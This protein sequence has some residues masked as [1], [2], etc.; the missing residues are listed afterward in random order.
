MP[1]IRIA[2]IGLGLVSDAHLDSFKLLDNINIV[3]VCD[4]REE[5]TRLIA[6]EWNATAYSDYQKLLAKEQV[7][8]V[9][10]LTPASIHLDVIKTAA[11]VGTHIFCEKPIAVSIEDA[12]AIINVCADAKVKLFYGS[13]YRYLPAVRAA[14]EL[15]RQGKI[16]EIQLMSEQGVGGNGL[17]NCSQLSFTHYPEGGPGGPAWGIMDH[18]VHLVDVFSWFADSKIVDVIGQG[19]ISGGAPDTEYMIMKFVSGAMGHLLY[20]AASYSTVLPNEGMYSG[21]QGYR[22]DSS[23]SEPGLW[24][25]D[26]DSISVYGTT[27]SLRI[28]Y[29]T[30]A[31]YLNTGDG[32]KQIP[33]SGRTPFG[34]F[35]TQLETCIASIVEDLPPPISGEVGKTTLETMLR[36]YQ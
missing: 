9:L 15:I 1:D 14:Y 25:G 29:Y 19:N 36:I 22:E 5:A 4:I 27:G 24:E 12:A 2:I 35:A 7:D 3:A 33:L 21:G 26:P 20:N 10:V 8:L 28:F 30:N 11:A 13:C 6:A 32:P 17:E 34:H 31:L 16:G 18:G 23:I